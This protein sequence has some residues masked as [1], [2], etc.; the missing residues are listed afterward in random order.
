MPNTDDTSS[1]FRLVLTPDKA[2]LAAT[3]PP[4]CV[5]VRLQAPDLP[6]R[7]AYRAVM[8]GI[9]S[10]FLTAADLVLQFAAAKS[11]S[12]IKEYP[13]RTVIGPRLLV[14]DEI[15]YLPFGREKPISSS[16]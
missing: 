10:R 7:L 5:F 12:R 8:A 11:Q 15:G 14:I 2:A 3:V 4:R 13:N 6:D 16:T 1:D 9:K